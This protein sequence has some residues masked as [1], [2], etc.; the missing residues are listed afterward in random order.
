V[1]SAADRRRGASATAPRSEWLPGLLS[2]LLFLLLALRD[3]GFQ[4]TLWY[5]VGLALLALLAL[6]V[7]S[8]VGTTPPRATLVALGALATYAAW[9]FA[10]IAWAD[11]RGDAFEGANRTLVYAIGFALFA[12]MPVPRGLPVVLGG[13]YAAGVAAVALA[14][15]VRAERDPDPGSFFIDGR[16][17]EPAGYANAAAALFLG[18]FWIGV[19]LSA[20]RSLPAPLRATMTGAAA[21]LLGA[22]TLCQSRASVIA[23]AATCVI[24]LALVPGRARSVVAL[25]LPAVAVG[26]VLP[27]L[28][29]VFPAAR[30]G[31]TAPALRDA[32]PALGLAA[33]VAALA[34]WL[35]AVLETRVDRSAATARRV[36]AAVLGGAALVVL[37]G[38]AWVA[39]AAAPTERLAQGWDEFTQLQEPADDE[40]HLASGL[41]SNRYDFWRVALDE[42]TK[43]P[44]TGLGADNFAADYVRERRSHEEPLHP[45]SLAVR[46]VSQTGI[47]GTALFGLFLAAAG[48]AAMRARGRTRLEHA[49]LLGGIVASSYWLIHGLVDWFWPFAGLTLPA[50]AWLGLAGNGAVTRPDAA[51]LP[52]P[53]ALRA[54]AAAVA[55]AVALVLVPPWLSAKEIRA[56]ATGW[57]SNPAAAL[58]RLDRARELNPLTDDADVVAGIIAGRRGDLAA[59][60]AAYERALE[61]NPTNWFAHLELALAAGDSGRRSH[62]LAHLQ[63]ARRLNPREPILREVAEALRAGRRV[64]RRGIEAKFDARAADLAR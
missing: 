32:L 59:L 46:V 50:L 18:A 54:A 34:A 30:Q 13:L 62:Q 61:R 19:T 51:P 6:V 57:P 52:R 49:A 63:A 5:P 64:D 16:F 55:V 36:A 44:L 25:T 29:D 43:R 3:A 60:T 37:G 14:S 31:E 22:A 41:G 24:Q 27:T 15:V 7:A 40:S 2:V 8:G 10:S 9:C 38:G 35:L 17:A 53:R 28:L 56:A 48:T 47:P 58:E 26:A 4:P 21:V 12:L 39:V 45:H 33:A 42:F 1:R 23:F 11:V 20:R